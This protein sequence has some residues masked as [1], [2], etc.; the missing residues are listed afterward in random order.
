M[1]IDQYLLF[2]AITSVF[3]LSPGPSV[4]FSINNGVRHGIKKSSI[5][6]LGNIFA[7]QL[8]TVLSTLGLGAVLTASNE[9]FNILKYSGAAYLIYL[10]LKIWRAPVVLQQQ[11]ISAKEQN[12]DALTL[13]RRGFLVT[14]SNPKLLVYISALLPQFIDTQQALIPQM[15]L[16]GITSALVMCTVFMSYAI[17]G[18]KS[19]CWFESP[20]KLK[21][22]N[23]FS[24]VTF[25]SFGTALG[26]SENKI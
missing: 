16:L 15:V 19:R 23:R 22:F 14:S 5:A 18:T 3:L 7:F 20:K 24:G 12:S 13:F 10:G 2:V 1:N 8:F 25:I 11:A 17:I 26:F 21:L 6:V 9:I 4:M